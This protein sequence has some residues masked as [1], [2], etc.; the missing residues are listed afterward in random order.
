MDGGDAGGASVEIAAIL[1][2]ALLHGAV[3]E[4]DLGAVA[5]GPGAS[6]GTAAGFENGDLEARLAELVGGDQAGDAGAEDDDLLA[7]AEVSG[8]LGQRRD[9]DGRHQPEGLHG[10]KGGSVS[11][12]LGDALDEDTSGEAHAMG[13]AQLSCRLTTSVCNTGGI[14]ARNVSGPGRKPVEAAGIFGRGDAVGGLV[15]S[16]RDELVPQ[17][18]ELREL[19]EHSGVLRV[20]VEQIERSACCAGLA[21]QGCQEGS[22]HRRVEGIVKIEQHRA[23]RA[24]L[25]RRRHPRRVPWPATSRAA[26]PARP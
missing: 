7:A 26:L 4:L 24:C 10:R 8:Q 5:Y 6:A 23:R 22:Q 17:E 21:Q 14:I 16:E 20:E 2:G 18:F 3:G 25:S 12:G 1:P 15:R 11:A 9:A 13:S 19:R